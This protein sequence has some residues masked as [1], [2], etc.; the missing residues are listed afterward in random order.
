MAND[1]HSP[2]VVA[3][4]PP[5]G[6]E[7]LRLGATYRG[8]YGGHKGGSRQG[9]STIFRSDGLLFIELR[10]AVFAVADADDLD[11]V[12]SVRW[13]LRESKKA[14]TNYAGTN[15]TNGQ[16]GLLHRRLLDAPPALTVDHINGNGLDNRRQNLRLCTHSENMKNLPRNGKN[17]TGHRGVSFHAATGKYIAQIWCDNQHH[18]LGRHD[19]I[20]EAAA[21]YALAARKLHGE[22]AR[23]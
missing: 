22:F 3:M 14:R 15:S 1:A 16:S 21:A 6:A 23:P 20:E 18:W 17:V 4:Q 5:E 11:A 9:H 13:H 19:T 2:F 7:L 12:A 8:R 10:D